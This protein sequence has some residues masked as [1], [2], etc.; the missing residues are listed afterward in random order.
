MD[1]ISLKLVFM[2]TLVFKYSGICLIRHIKGIRKVTI[3]ANRW[4]LS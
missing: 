2:S 3:Y 1:L 4:K